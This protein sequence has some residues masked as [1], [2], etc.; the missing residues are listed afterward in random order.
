[1]SE[2][3]ESPAGARAHEIL[4]LETLR[5]AELRELKS[6]E[7]KLALAGNQELAR[8]VRNRRHDDDLKLAFATLGGRGLPRA[9]K[10]ALAKR[11]SEYKERLRPAYHSDRLACCQNERTRRGRRRMRRSARRA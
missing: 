5:P 3:R 2:P 6:L 9:E 7:Q 8:E 1:M 11:L 4:G 10:L